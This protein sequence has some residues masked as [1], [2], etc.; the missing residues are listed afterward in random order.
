MEV[1][2]FIR[3]GQRLTV[4]GARTKTLALLCFVV[5]SYGKKVFTLYLAGVAYNCRLMFWG[6]GRE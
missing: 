3:L 2:V 5:L 1:T 4:L 6:I